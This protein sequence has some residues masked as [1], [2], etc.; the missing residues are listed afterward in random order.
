[1][2]PL[3][4]N[5][6]YHF[7]QINYVAEYPH[8]YIPLLE[9]FIADEIANYQET[10]L[11]VKTIE[12]TVDQAWLKRSQEQAQLKM[13]RSLLGLVAIDRRKHHSKSSIATHVS[14]TAGDKLD[15]SSSKI[16]ILRCIK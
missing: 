13:Q 9:K 2:V 12:K 1:M 10:V 11:P 15:P 14:L 3:A 4:P 16:A 7:D 5:Y 6:Q 8:R